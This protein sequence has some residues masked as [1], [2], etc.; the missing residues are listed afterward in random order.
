MNKSIKDYLEIDKK[1]IQPNFFPNEAFCYY[2][3][4]DFDLNGKPSIA[5]GREIESNKF[6]IEAGSLL[7][8]K[9]NPRIKRVWLANHEDEKRRV[10][11]TE[12]VVLRPK[13][14]ADSTYF[15]YYLQQDN[16]Y[17]QLESNAIG[18][19]NSHVRFK[20]EFLTTIKVDIPKL[21]VQQKI[22]KIL[23]KVDGQI[24]KTEAIIAKYK[25]IKQGLM[26]DLF[27]RG[28]D[29]A[30]GKLRPRYQDAPELYKPSPLGMIPKEWDV[31]ILANQCFRSGEYGINAA[32]VPFSHSLPTYLRI[33]DI[34]D[35]GKFAKE[36]KRSVN[37]PESSKYL[38]SIGDIVFAR[39]GATVGKT[40]LYNPADG[41]LVF[42]GFL[43]KFS[44]D[45]ALLLSSFLKYYTETP[46]YLNWVQVMSMRSG[47]PGI[48]GN[49]YGKMLLPLPDTDEQKAISKTLNANTEIID[50]ETTNLKKLQQLKKGLMSDLLSGKVRVQVDEEAIC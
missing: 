38:L 17:K 3:L 1:G 45:P 37:S 11:S 22:A 31:D 40:Y 41:P 18:S 25:A 6:L 23:R 28:I 5:L 34:T 19:T 46:A 2:S 50:K 12:F 43:I 14:T 26:Q 27:T 30:T 7:I 15:F 39:T 16:L 29:V 49:E 48:N 4:P 33:T 42:A 21:R 13:E 8:S 47:Q 35:E 9:L 32:S 24:E 10:S 20:P 44:P 36:D